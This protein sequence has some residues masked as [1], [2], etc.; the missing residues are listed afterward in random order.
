MNTKLDGNCVILGGGGH[1]KILIES[2]LLNGQAVPCAVLDANNER[3]GD[4]IL[5]V[6]IIGGDDSLPELSDRGVLYFVV[7][8]GSIG[9]NRPRQQL[10]E[11]GLASKLCPISVQHPQAVC[12]QWAKVGQGSQL[13]PLCVVNPGAILGENVIVNSGAIVEHDCV[14]ED[15]VHVAPGVKLAGNVRVGRGGHV[16]IG[17]TVK[18]GIRIGQGAIVGA[19]AVVVN[20]VQPHSVVVGV[21]ARPHK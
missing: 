19:G 4:S 18:E 10:F 20:S 7:G 2:L 11:F 1:A 16:G 13:L 3:W 12:S 15:H 17:A 9:D 21:P 8:L 14:I 5:G 6:P